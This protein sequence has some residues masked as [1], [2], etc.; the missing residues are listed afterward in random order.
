MAAGIGA[1]RENQH[2]RTHT[3]DYRR[4]E[5]GGWG[6]S[7]IKKLD[8]SR[9]LLSKEQYIADKQARMYDYQIMYKYFGKSNSGTIL[10]ALKKEWAFTQAEELSMNRLPDDYEKLNPCLNDDLLMGTN[11]AFFKAVVPKYG[12]PRLV[13][14]APDMYII[15]KRIISDLPTNR[16]WL[17]PALEKVARAIINKIES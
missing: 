11:P 5:E 13:A 12:D 9:E 1:Q 6:M 10:R 7:M 2:S 8:I 16:D 4:S 3:Q 14:A 15:L 17:D